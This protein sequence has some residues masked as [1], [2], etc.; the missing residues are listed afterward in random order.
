MAARFFGQWL[1][2]HGL[3]TPEQLLAALDL[4]LETNKELGAFAVD[5]K[6]LTKKQADD[7]NVK[8]RR[9]DGRFGEIAIAEGLLTAKQVDRLLERACELLEMEKA[10]SS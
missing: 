4:Q 1:I 7:I 9:T 3:I 2:R 6:V 10:V 8:Q 5:L